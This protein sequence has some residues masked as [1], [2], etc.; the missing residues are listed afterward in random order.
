MNRATICVI[1]LTTFAGFVSPCAAQS[2][3]GVWDARQQQRQTTT[4][5]AGS[6][7]VARTAV[8]SERTRGRVSEVMENIVSCGVQRR[9][10][11]HVPPSYDGSQPMPVVL[12]LHGAGMNIEAM[13]GL[14]LMDFQADRNGFLAVYP[15]G[16]SGGWNAGG[17]KSKSNA[18][19]VAYID[20][21]LRHLKTKYNVDQ[22]AVYACG[23][24][25]GGQMVQKLACDLSQQISAIGVV[26]IT[27]FDSVCKGCSAR[28]S[29]P[30]MFFIGTEDPLC[31]REGGSGKQLGALGD[32]L[33]IGDLHLTPQ[34]AKFA[35]IMTAEE[36]V[37]FW[38][39]HNGASSSRQE[40]MPDRN[41]R[42][43][44][45]VTKETFGGGD[46]EVVSYT[47]D[48]GGHTW[49]GGMGWVVEGKLGKTCT[50][51]SA[52][53]LLWEFFRNHRRR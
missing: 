40:R 16:V 42:D 36:I 18:N 28:R 30:V 43:G 10:L 12:L 38:A 44:C 48:G 50:D 19:D 5:N 52:S 45:T 13:R 31:P 34:L 2:G 26:A 32:S 17:M 37:D 3:K 22:Q 41:T 24:S 29:M 47:I 25:N 27:G 49:P 15:E 6:T 1:L 4:S 14:T 46:R 20:D 7:A 35:D 33:G 21:L 9:Y 8:R 53:E 11:V 51:I 23:I 39:R